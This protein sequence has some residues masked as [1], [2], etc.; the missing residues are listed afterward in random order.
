MAATVTDDGSSLEAGHVVLVTGSTDG[1][2][3]ETARNLAETGATILVHGRD[4]EKGERLAA[5]L[6]GE[7]HR[8]YAA[9]FANPA[10]I[11]ELADAVRA[12]FDRLDVLVNN[13][14]TFQGE[15]HLVDAPGSDEG[16]ELTFAVNH[17]A[18]FLL[19]NLLADRLAETGARRAEEADGERDPARVVSISSNLHRDRELDLDD[20]RGPEGQTGMDAYEHSKLANVLFTRELARRL[21]DAVTANSCH[22]GVS[23]T[24][25]LTRDGSRGFGLVWSLYGVVG[26][27]LGRTD[28]PAESAET[29]TY[30]ARS[31]SVTGVTGEYFDDREP[32]VP[33]D[34]AT[35]REAQRRL[36]RASAE[37]LA[38]GETEVVGD[39]R[40]QRA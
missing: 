8:F 21:P 11:R 22:P 7:G 32:V 27:L 17:L 29:P 30:L 16:V 39:E 34:G 23:P 10:A 3:A 31:P 1:I 6:P 24:T 26:G 15:R 40:P 13:A 38:L 18:P 28:S 37:W 20:V 33:G 12:D 4:R 2:G 9:D 19:T 5:D 25:A 36:W 35:D 14:G